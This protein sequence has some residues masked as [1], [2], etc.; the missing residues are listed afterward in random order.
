[1]INVYVIYSIEYP[2]L[3]V[4]VFDTQTECSAFLGITARAIN[5]YIN[6]PEHIYCN[7]YIIAKVFLDNDLTNEEC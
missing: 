4:A 2:Y 1:M 3:P 5:M 6:N 7:K